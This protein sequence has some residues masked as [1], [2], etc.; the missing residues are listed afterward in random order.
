MQ[1]YMEQKLW[2]KSLYRNKR[3]ADFQPIDGLINSCT[4][5]SFPYTIK[6]WNKLPATMINTKNPI[7]LTLWLKNFLNVCTVA[8]INLFLNFI[9]LVFSNF[10]DPKSDSLPYHVPCHVPMKCFCSP[11]QSV[12]WMV[13][14]TVSC[15]IWSLC[16]CF[17]VHYTYFT[18]H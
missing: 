13:I 2:T 9:Q 18:W 8:P 11:L 17:L 6:A 1:L 14:C 15:S 10:H 3:C 12:F 5:S 7:N 16:T 4:R